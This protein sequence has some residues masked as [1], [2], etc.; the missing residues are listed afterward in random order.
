MSERIY[1]MCPKMAWDTCSTGDCND[2]FPPTYD[3]DGFIHAT[4]DPSMLI[5]IANHFY[6]DAPRDQEWIILV[7]DCARLTSRLVFEPA[8]AVGTTPSFSKTGGSD[9]IH[10][11][12][13]DD[14]E[15]SQ[16]RDEILFPHIYGTIQKESVVEILNMTRDSSG[17]FVGFSS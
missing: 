14:T 17:I 9:S 5:P 15:A 8:A 2:Y 13:V 3:Q 16:H 12:H 10:D 4:Q 7:I 1:H 11:R 6:K